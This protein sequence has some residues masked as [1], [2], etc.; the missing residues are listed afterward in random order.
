MG[1]TALTA[2]VYGVYLG[3]F[4]I[5]GIVM[6]LELVLTIGNV[7]LRGVFVLFALHHICEVVLSC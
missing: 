4:D 5:I 7:S 1:V 6:L 3:S 2:S